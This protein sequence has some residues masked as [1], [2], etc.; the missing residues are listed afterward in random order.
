VRHDRLYASGEGKLRISGHRISHPIA[1]AIDGANR[2][3]FAIAVA[4]VTS[5]G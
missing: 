4:A 2:I 5:D 1:K 3:A